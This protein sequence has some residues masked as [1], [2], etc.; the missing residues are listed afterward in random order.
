MQIGF[1]V[2]VSGSWA[3]PD[4]QV[5]I[6]QRAEELGYASLWTFQRLLFPAE[7]RA[8]IWGEAYRSVVD[9]IVTL[10][11]LAGHTNRIRLGLA[12]A[13]MPFF[14]PVLLAKQLAS[15]DLVSTGRLD[16]GLGM[17]WARQE[18]AASNV[19]LEHRGRRAEEF[20][21]LLRR[22][23]TDDVVD[24]RGEFYTVPASRMEPKPIQKPRPPL[25]LGGSAPAALRRAG[26]LADGWVSG[27]T[28]D[29]SRI[30][31][32]IEIVKQSA[33]EAGRNPEILRF[34]CRGVVRPGATDG[35]RKPL[36]DSLDDIRADLLVLEGHGVTEFF[37]DLNFDPAVGSP[38]AD[39]AESMRRAEQLLEAFA[40]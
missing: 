14:S 25:V 16:V 36:T 6:A 34:V 27:S 35:E 40:P 12:V 32:S 29:L 3:T 38:D 7:P 13:V 15:V 10:S 17:G 33:L 20:L 30:G 28:A 39:P 1:A 18:Y 31:E 5:R 4:N 9:P 19:S 24:F 37:I 21:E 11:Y 8:A 23:W 26:R 2:P 22:L